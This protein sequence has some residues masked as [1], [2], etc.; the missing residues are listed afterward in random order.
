MTQKI[1]ISIKD[2]QAL[3]EAIAE[4]ATSPEGDNLAARAPSRPDAKRDSD[5]AG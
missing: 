4:I 1:K 2:A 5:S 3:A